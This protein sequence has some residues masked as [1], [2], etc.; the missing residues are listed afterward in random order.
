MRKGFLLSLL[1]PL[2][3]LDILLQLTVIQPFADFSDSSDSKNREKLFLRTYK[4]RWFLCS[5]KLFQFFP[6]LNVWF[7]K[8]CLSWLRRKATGK[9]T[10]RRRN[11]GNGRALLG[12]GYY[13]SEPT[14]IVHVVGKIK[15]SK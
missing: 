3:S 1:S 11:V 13:R 12:N 14:V 5:Q 8:Y 9:A 4:K 6:V 2:L 15:N 10:G 7:P